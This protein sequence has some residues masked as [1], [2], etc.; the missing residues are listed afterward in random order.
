MWI[1]QRHFAQLASHIVAIG[2][3]RAHTDEA[4]Q[5]LIARNDVGSTNLTRQRVCR[6]RIAR[7]EQAKMSR[8]LGRDGNR[9]Q[10][11]FEIAHC[12]LP[13]VRQHPSGWTARTVSERF[14]RVGVWNSIL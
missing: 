2:D 7:G 6:P 3:Q 5:C 12:K 1:D 4:S 11:E 13:Y 8:I 14:S 10:F 9:G